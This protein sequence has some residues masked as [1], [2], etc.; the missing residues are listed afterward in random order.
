MANYSVLRRIQ[1]DRPYEEGETIALEPKMA[2]ELIAIGAIDP[3]PIKA[4]APPPPP[5]EKNTG[6]AKT[7]TTSTETT[8]EGESPQT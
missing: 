8:E 2:K 5:P 3:K 1:G 7:G 6:K 4:A